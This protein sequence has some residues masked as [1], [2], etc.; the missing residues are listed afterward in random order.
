MVYYS[1]M[2]SI[3]KS[4]ISIIVACICLYGL[5]YFYSDR[6]NIGLFQ[7][8]ESCKTTLT[9]T[10]TKVLNLIDEKS[11]AII[12]GSN[13]NTTTPVTPTE[14]TPPTI[15]SI[16]SIQKLLNVDALV[17]SAILRIRQSIANG[18]ASNPESAVNTEKTRVHN[19]FEKARG[20]CDKIP[21]NKTS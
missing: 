1:Y 9:T 17:D 15:D 4:L 2:E 16:A 12:L 13:S 19:L 11:N 10:E 5:W 7:S 20:W 14:T 6:F 18:Q 8:P 21:F 3:K